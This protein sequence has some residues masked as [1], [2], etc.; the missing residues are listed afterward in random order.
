MTTLPEHAQRPYSVNQLADRWG[1]SPSMIRKLISSNRLQP[2]RIGELI[3][4]SAAE[5]E[6]YELCQVQQT[7]DSTPSKSSAEGSPSSGGSLETAAS[8]CATESNF[9][10]QIARARR[11]KPGRSCPS[12]TIV[13]GPWGGS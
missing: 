9:N 8:E 11:R 3:R 10:P 2:F 1:C 12:P 7:T 5:V 6:R 4:I 13:H